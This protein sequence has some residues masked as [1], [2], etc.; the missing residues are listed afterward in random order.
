MRKK[1]LD[2]VEKNI[3]EFKPICN[4][5]SFYGTPYLYCH[6][7]VDIRLVFKLL[8]FEID[9]GKPY[10]ENFLYFGGSKLHSQLISMN[11]KKLEHFLN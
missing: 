5:Y 2:F 4:K 1:I 9:I 6:N 10:H 3:R 7:G 8:T 11:E